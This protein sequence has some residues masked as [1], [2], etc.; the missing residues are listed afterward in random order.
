MPYLN[1]AYYF[2][3][4]FVF[5]LLQ[6]KR[7]CILHVKLQT[8]IVA[9]IFQTC[10]YVCFARALYYI[11]FLYIISILNGHFDFKLEIYQTK[12]YLWQNEF[13]M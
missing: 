9:A 11:F 8:C 6:Y 13:E 10:L 4:F 5:K 12:P 7:L 2:T 3:I 1:I